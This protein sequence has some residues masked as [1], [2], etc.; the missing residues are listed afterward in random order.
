VKNAS[1]FEL[2]TTKLYRS[3]SYHV[4]GWVEKHTL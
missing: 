2:K 1:N 3:W 4:C